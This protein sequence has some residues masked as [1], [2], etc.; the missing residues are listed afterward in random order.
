MAEFLVC[1]LL[2]SVVDVEL[3]RFSWFV[4]ALVDCIGIDAEN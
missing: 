4:I 2:D 3:S 1:D